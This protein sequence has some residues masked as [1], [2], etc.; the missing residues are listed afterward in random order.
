MADLVRNLTAENLPF[1]R[2]A[3]DE[4]TIVSV[5][6]VLRSGWLTTG[7]RCA[8]FEAALSIYCGN[9]PV[10]LFNSGTITLAIALEL[11]NVKPGDEVI[12]T[13]LT[14]VAC[15][16]VIVHRG[17][18]PVFVDID[19]T[20]RNIDLDKIT[21]AITPRT[22]A[23]MPVDMAGLPVD[24]TRLHAL[25]AEHQLRV[26]EDAAQSLGASWHG[27]AIGSSFAQGRDFVSFSFHANKNLTTGEGGCLVLPVDID[28][29]YVERLRLQGVA[30]SQA[31][32]DVDIA[33]Y[34]GNL[35][36]IAAAIGL[37]Q[38]RRL[39]EFTARRR[40]LARM[41]F[42]NITATSGLQLPL[43]DFDNCNW[44]MFQLLLPPTVQRSAF[45]ERM[46]SVG[47]SIGVHYPAI[48][49]FSYYRQLGYKPESTPIA[50]DVSE[51]I[52]TLPL[53]PDMQ[54]DNVLR[55]CRALNDNL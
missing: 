53:F 24:R 38:L 31:G 52:V 35:T 29:S 28:P 39:E 47:I 44:H 5:G 17:A 37:G 33:G 6:E 16:N 11:I 48:N 20:T 50:Y 30:R 2:P 23:I 4:A 55:V 42:D 10:K 32:M 43:A 27:Q 46:S 14:W 8:E 19:P 45:I 7:S 15:A 22:R 3:I 13:P 25:A 12:T 36:D 18:R 34:K 49:S 9:R 40:Y 41:Y 51:R 26:I 21:A 1:T 54:D